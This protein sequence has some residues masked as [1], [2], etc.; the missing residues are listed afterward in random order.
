MSTTTLTTIEIAINQLR[1]ILPQLTE[2]DQEVV[3]T[4]L[5]QLVMRTMQDL[6]EEIDGGDW[7]E[8]WHNWLEQYTPHKKSPQY[9]E[10]TDEEF[11][12]LLDGKSNANS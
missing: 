10:Q 9:R 4:E 2:K 6:A 12:A 8:E 1:V 5:H 3:A 11:L 7:P